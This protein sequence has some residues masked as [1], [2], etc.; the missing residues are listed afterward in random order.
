MGVLDVVDCCEVWVLLFYEC[1][2]GF[3]IRGFVYE[4]FVGYEFVLVGGE[5]LFGVIG[6]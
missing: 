3:V 5:C 2:H 4:W 6:V 1:G